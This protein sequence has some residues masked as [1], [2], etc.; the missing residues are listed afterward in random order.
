MRLVNGNIVHPDSRIQF[1][2]GVVRF[3]NGNGADG[4][5]LPREHGGP[6][7]GL[8]EWIK[9]P[10]GTRKLLNGMIQYPDGS[11]KLPDGV[12][13]AGAIPASLTWHRSG[14]GWWCVEW[15]HGWV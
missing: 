6:A 8:V 15:G 12:L 2:N 9:L 5:P 3:P 7:A 4:T 10:D 14:C 13:A 1:P 11:V